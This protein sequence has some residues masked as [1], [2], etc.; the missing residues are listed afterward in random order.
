M[1]ALIGGLMG[2]CTAAPKEILDT[3]SSDSFFAHP[4]SL[5]E[6]VTGRVSLAPESLGWPKGSTRMVLPA[7]REGGNGQVVGLL[8][9]DGQM[10]GSQTLAPYDGVVLIDE[11]GQVLIDH[12]SAV[13]W[14]TDL[15]ILR[16]S[17]LDVQSLEERAGAE[18]ASLF[19]GPLLLDGGR[20]L[21]GPGVEVGAAR[22]LT[23]YRDGSGHLGVL[24]S[25]S[26]RPTLREHLD[27]LAALD[28]TEAVALDPFGMS[29]LIWGAEGAGPIGDRAG[30]Y[31]TLEWEE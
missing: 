11:K 27:E 5:G 9:V 30:G 10:V 6:R 31:L 3:T 7:A 22:R 2:G 15:F 19:Q 14:G 28:A 25:G 23:L 4:L 13:E 20:N 16:G 29:G 17:K 18:G 12:V 24:D 26:R 21:S 1:T 8:V